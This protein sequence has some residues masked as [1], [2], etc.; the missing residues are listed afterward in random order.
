VFQWL[1]CQPGFH[2]K[3]ERRG[4]VASTAILRW[5]A[6]RARISIASVNALVGLI[7]GASQIV[8]TPQ[9]VEL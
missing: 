5:W 8:E 3:G 9:H 2:V 1:S 7:A 6:G 4:R